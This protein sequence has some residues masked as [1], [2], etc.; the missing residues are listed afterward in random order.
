MRLRSALPVFLLSLLLAACSRLELVYENADWLAARQIAAYLDLDR[1]QRQQVREALQAYRDVHRR[2]RLPDL[3]AWLESADPVLDAGD[4]QPVAMARLFDDGEAL[5]REIA[6]DLIPPAAEV[7]RSLTAGQRQHL[8]EQLASGRQEY[9]EER[10]PERAE[11]TIERI[12]GWT[13][14]L[15]AGQREH[16]R[17]CDAR[18]P[19]V[20]EDWLAWREQRDAELIALLEREPSQR[21]VEA[22]LADWWLNEA[23]RGETLQAARLQSRRVWQECSTTLLATLTPAQRESL[24]DRMQRYR[25]NFINLASR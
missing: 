19:D 23:A 5:L 25:G 15:G 18:L 14:L 21:A 1:D 16:L 12:E 2:E 7:L 11:R 13:G 10:M 3:I 6:A 9:A 24:R 8:A 20:T 4:S 17:R 22:F